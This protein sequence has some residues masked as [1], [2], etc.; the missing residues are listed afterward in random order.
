MASGAS[1]K[2]VGPY[3]VLKKVGTGSFASVWHARHKTSGQ[4]VAIKAISTEK[5]N[6]KL[7]ENLDVEISIQRSLEHPNV[8]KL[9][10]ILRTE[11]TIYLILEFCAG[12]DL[13]KF[14]RRRGPLPEEFAKH[15]LRQLARGLDFLRRH[16]LIH[17][18]L[19][20]QNLLLSSDGDDATL[21]IADF[22]FARYIDKGN[23][24]ETLCGS[25]LYMAPEILRFQKY[26][27]KADL[28]QPC[29]SSD[30]F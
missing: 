12:G 16:S 25:P 3:L 14:I 27:A 23:L 4:E 20:P 11:R 2:S 24:A 13:S 7:T 26:D 19:K 8:V 17:R 6:K 18:D 28:C 21:K 30:L 1:A 15:L 5:L 10:D 22:G 29:H 9:L